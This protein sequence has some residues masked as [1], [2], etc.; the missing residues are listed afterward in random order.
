MGQRG[1]QGRRVVAAAVHD[2]VDEQGGGAEHLAR[3]QAAVDVATDP[4][5]YYGAGPVAVE[6]R[7]VQAEL[8]GVP[9][10]VA[11]FER[12]LPVEQQL[13]RDAAAGMRRIY[14]YRYPLED[15]GARRA[16][17]VPSGVNKPS[18]SS[19]PGRVTAIIV[20]E[21][22]YGAGPVAVEGRDVQAELGG[23]RMG[24]RFWSP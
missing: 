16:Y 13:V 22:Y 3:G 14:E 20:N 19:T 15:A 23:G 6:G 2:T 9:A 8:G 5:G 17:G 12:L 24:R 1:Q 18:S 4:V 10:Q 11:V 7:D 21:R